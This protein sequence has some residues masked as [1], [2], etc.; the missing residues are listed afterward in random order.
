MTIL[1]TVLRLH[2]WQLD[3]RR[4]YLTELES[5][6]ER[7]RADALRLRAD[8]DADGGAVSAT[9]RLIDRRNKLEHSI[10]E[11]EHQIVAARAAAIAAE[12]E[13]GAHEL[14]AAQRLT[15]G[16]TMR[17]ARRTRDTVP[18]RIPIRRHGS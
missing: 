13:M 9:Q 1:D 5:L 3:E 10:A 17:R 12:R 8:A 7:L 2:R 15:F 14:A 11:I 18:S 4:R 16:S 6:A